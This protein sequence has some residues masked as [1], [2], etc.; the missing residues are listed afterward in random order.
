M[1]K[2][3]YLSSQLSI[4]NSLPTIRSARFFGN[5]LR[6]LDSSLLIE[7]AL[8][9]IAAILAIRIFDGS[10]ISRAAWFVAPGIWVAAALIPT[11][12]KRS[13]FAKIGF[14]T[15]QIGLALL[16]V[17]WTCVVVFPAM[18]CGL[19]LLRSYG[20]ELPLR[21]VPL[22]NQEWVFWLFYQFMY[23]AV[24]EEVFFRGYVQGNILR[25]T[26]MVRGEESRLTQWISIVISAAV[27]AVAHIIVQGQT[28]SVLTFLPGLVL[29]WLFSRTGSL[30]A[31]ILFHGLANAC[32]LV[33]AAVFT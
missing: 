24:A 32:Y 28:I 6:R 14:T 11:A 23:V 21:A 10:S 8:V 25:L 7:T 18:F 15:K 30:L 12:V 20:L 13:K 4:T 22:Q 17:F 19:W 26:N 33:M 9:A 3:G 27:F 5:R 16:L 29:G 1:L 31:P 2:M